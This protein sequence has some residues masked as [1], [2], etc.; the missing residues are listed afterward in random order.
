MPR[1]E[2][3]IIRPDG[4]IIGEIYE[5]KRFLDG[6]TVLTSEV[7]FR[8][9]DECGQMF[10]VTTKSGTVYRLGKKFE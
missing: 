9:I 4:K 6:H 8:K 2:N 10:E 5:D 1:L 3:W 7:I